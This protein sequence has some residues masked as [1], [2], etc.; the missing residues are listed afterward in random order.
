MDTAVGLQKKLSV[1]GIT[2]GLVAG[3]SGS[4]FVCVVEVSL[5]RWCSSVYSVA[6]L[7][8]ISFSLG[9]AA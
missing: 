5:K 7:S 2:I 9:F 4:K 6:L 3:L 1:V 8:I